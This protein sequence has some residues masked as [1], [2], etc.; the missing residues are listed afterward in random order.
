[1]VYEAYPSLIPITKINLAIVIGKE[2][3]DIC[4]GFTHIY[5]IAI[6]IKTLYLFQILRL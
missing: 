4:N 1:M 2:K 3:M 5:K 6:M